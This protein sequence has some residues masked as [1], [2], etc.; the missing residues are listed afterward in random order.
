[1]LN[2]NEYFGSLSLMAS[3]VAI[4]TGYLN[5]HV[6]FLKNANGTWKQIIS[7]VISIVVVFIGQLKSVGMV[8]ETSA[9]WT[10]ITGVAVGLVANGIFDIKI[11]QAILSFIKANKSSKA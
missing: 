9:L 10:G 4:I 2:I 1:M 6:P 7:W 11:V 8:A 3:L 5:T